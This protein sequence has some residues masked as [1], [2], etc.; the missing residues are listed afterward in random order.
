[1]KQLLAAFL[2]VLVVSSSFAYVSASCDYTAQDACQ[3]AAQTCVA[4]GINSVCQCLYTLGTCESNAGCL[5][6]ASHDSFVSQ[7]ERA[8]CSSSYC[9]VPVSSSCSGHT[10]CSS[11]AADTCA[12]CETTRTCIDFANADYA[13]CDRLHLTTAS[14]DG[15]LFLS[16]LLL[17][18][19]CLLLRLLLLSLVR[20]QVVT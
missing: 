16:L 20:V 5:D 9:N 4:N 11:C 1:M 6:Q 17:F 10:S 19:L 13:T 8:G 14:C 12:W 2:F 18:F 3:T 15:M 7:C